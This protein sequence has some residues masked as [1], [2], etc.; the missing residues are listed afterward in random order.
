MVEN[1]EQISEKQIIATKEAINKHPDIEEMGM[2]FDDLLE[3]YKERSSDLTDLTEKDLVEDMLEAGEIATSYFDEDTKNDLTPDDIIML[4]AI[5][6]SEDLFD[7]KRIGN[8]MVQDARKIIK[9]D[10]D[11]DFTELFELFKEENPNLGHLKNPE[12]QKI[13]L[14]DS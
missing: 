6:M 14:E 1:S 10:F 4:G 2:D 11:L 3:L 8:K 12:A 9:E 7:P 5:S 13:V